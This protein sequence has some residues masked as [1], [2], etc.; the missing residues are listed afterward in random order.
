MKSV[1][2][3]VNS[4]DTE[5]LKSRPL[6]DWR[7]ILA[8]E[9]QVYV[10]GENYIGKRFDQI[11]Y[12]FCEK[13]EA[14]EILV[15][16]LYALLRYKYFPSTSEEI[17]ERIKAIVNSFTMNLKTTLKKVS[18]DKNADCDIVNMLPDYCIAFRNGVYNFKDDCWLFKYNIIKLDNLSNKIYAY[19]PNYIIMW[20][21]DYDFE[22]LPIAIKSTSLEEFVD[23]MK[24]LTIQ[25][26]NYCF[27]LLYN[28]SHD[29]DNK[30]DID[31]LKHLCEVFG[32][33]MLQSFSQYFVMLIGNGQNGKNSLFDGCLTNRLIPRPA[34][35]DIEAIENDRFITGSLE[36]KAQNIFLETEA[37][38]YT[39]SKMIKAL[40]G[41]M[42]QTIESK[43]VSKY[44][45]II[46]CKFVWSA[47]D[48]DK[49]KF[50][51]TTKGFR[52]RINMVE[53]YYQW[54]AQKRFLKKGDYY[55]T[56]FSDSL[57]EIKNDIV[58]TTTFVY[59]AMYGIML[60]TNN[61]VDSFKF[62]YNDWNMKYADIDMELK[63]KLDNISLKRIIDRCTTSPN[64]KEACKKGLYDC[65]RH[66]LAAS[67]TIKILGKN[68]IDGVLEIFSDPELYTAYFADNDIYI[69][70]RLLQQLSLDL[71]STSAAFTSSVKK[72]YGITSFDT[73]IGNVP[74]IR[75]TFLSGKLKILV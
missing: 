29:I 1:K 37:K 52:R 62:D 54:D 55:D 7:P 70:I 44:S 50:S 74:Y 45:G 73:I 30:F 13:N 39:E 53:L 28:M 42:Y 26:Q 4:V 33:T 72:L 19:D 63:D 56:T 31:K 57:S 69:S 36:N 25:Q 15:D 61:F 9:V 23:I 12:K 40:T 67:P 38:V 41:S 34:A 11:H 35:N 27:E 18:F 3:L 47:N 2:D 16:N 20:Y 22:P 58:N 43:G 65:D 71:A 49:V 14:K 66:S 60:G 21:L 32:Y 51:D 59:F 46:N 8:Q 68:G 17:D 6:S 64:I 5:I 10:F 75:C 48:Q 24:T